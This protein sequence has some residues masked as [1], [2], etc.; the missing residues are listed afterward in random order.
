MVSGD[1]ITGLSGFMTPEARQM[2]SYS[3][4]Q[5]LEA[6][7]ANAP[8]PTQKALW[9][10]F[11]VAVVIAEDASKLS[12]ALRGYVMGGA[13]HKSFG[14]TIEEGEKRWK[15]LSEE[16]RKIFC[17]ELSRAGVTGKVD[18]ADEAEASQ[19]SGYPLEGPGRHLPATESR[20]KL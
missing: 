20:W 4:T 13:R 18:K 10:R 6:A 12:A 11:L 9:H 1:E 2:V 5:W 17:I 19:S 8:A 7:S 15:V 16:Q 14:P 3:Y